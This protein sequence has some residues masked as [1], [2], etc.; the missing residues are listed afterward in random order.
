MSISVCE[1]LKITYAR[2]VNKELETSDIEKLTVDSP[3]ALDKA[4]ARNLAYYFSK[5]Y[6]ACLG[7]SAPG[8]LITSE[9]FIDTI[10]P[11]PLWNTS[12]VLSCSD[13]YLAMALL[14]EKFALFM[15]SVGPSVNNGK[16]KICAGATIHET[17]KIGENVSIAANVVVEEGASV[18]KNTA[19]YPGCYIGPQ[20]VIGEN[21]V[22]FPN[23][24][25]YE[26][27]KIGNGVRIHSN[28]VIGSDGF[29]YA[30]VWDE[31]TKMPI[32][33][34]KIYHVGSVQIGADV[35]IGASSTVDRGTI[36]DTIIE[37][38]AKLD[39]QVH[40]GHNSKIGRGAI[41]CGGT[42]L[43]GRAEVGAFVY[44]G[45][46]TGIVNNIKVGDGAKVGAMSLITK[47][48][49]PGQ[50]AVGNPQREYR[51]HFKAHAALN[52]LVAKSKKEK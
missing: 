39:N 10:K 17:A 49:L 46:M 24:T 29:G 41:L 31:K 35:E 9:R 20:S 14:S 22:L 12:V 32:K 30:S 18:G 40:L 38:G 8:V 33:H 2:V 36:S 45:G 28:T 52:R 19:I 5:E 3:A 6:D 16:N 50:T 44:V 7:K 27:V 34:Q 25:I 42:C 51:E 37:E 26:Q 4:G 23:V 13:P 47:D 43:A 48:V 21:C 11:H 15:S 1:I